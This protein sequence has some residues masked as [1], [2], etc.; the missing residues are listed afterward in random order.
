MSKWSRYPDGWVELTAGVV[1]P[2]KVLAQGLLVPGVEGVTVDLVA[3]YHEWDERYGVTSLRVDG[4]LSAQ[5]SGSLLR[6]IPVQ[7]L[8]RTA[9]KDQARLRIGDD[10]LSVQ[11]FDRASLLQLGEGGPTPDA[12]RAVA[13]V[14]RLA[15]ATLDAPA[16]RVAEDFGLPPRTATHWVR[17]ARERGHFGARN[18]VIIDSDYERGRVLEMLA[19]E[20]LVEA[21]EVAP[22]RSP[23]PTDG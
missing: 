2:T 18:R 16:K 7:E 20:G 10:L 12:L 19:G 23:G 1:V 21:P 13:R 4:N 22:A 5:I 8:L 9:V 14:Y 6:Q 15:E 11:H 3:E 17:L